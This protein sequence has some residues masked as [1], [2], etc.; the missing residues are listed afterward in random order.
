[1]PYADELIPAEYKLDIEDIA[2]IAIV[3][4]RIP[5]LSDPSK[6]GQLPPSQ[7]KPLAAAMLQGC[8]QREDPLAIMQIL[9]ATYL[10][11]YTGEIQYKDIASLFPKG[12]IATY[13][14]TLE[15]L[16]AKAKSFQ[17]GPEALTLQGLLL[18]KS[19]QHEH[20][21]KC[22][23]EAVTLSTIAY[24]PYRRHP[25]QLPLIAPWNA[26]GYLLSADKDPKVRLQ[27]KTYFAQG[28][29][30]GDDPLS[31][32]ELAQLEERT[33]PKWLQYTSKAAASG[34]RQATVD[35]AA[36]YQSASA[37]K[38][39]VLASSSMRT[40]LSW[41]LGWRRGSA[42]SLA[43]E[44]LQAASIMGHKPSTMQLAEYWES[45]GD[46]DRARECW[47]RLSEPSRGRGEE[48]PQLMQV[49]KRR[50]AGMKA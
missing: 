46:K 9:T 35:L 49:A 26:L 13:R 43:R 38:S 28:A 27:A 36:F 7:H 12:E 42:A 3:T 23:L 6:R 31:Y 50:L 24:I 8:A 21:K 29:L 37:A 44:W 45:V 47:R 1:M 25:M 17:L 41:L 40:A 39:P 18:E 16:C 20:A 19:G 4:M 15:K 33:D 22:Y 14:K 34:H 5:D 32:Y 10:A 30:E 2:S 48:W 11:E